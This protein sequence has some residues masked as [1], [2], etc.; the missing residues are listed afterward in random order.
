[1]SP[2]PLLIL[3]LHLELW[4]FG[5]CG[6]GTPLRAGGRLTHTRAFGCGLVT[7]TL[8]AD[9]AFLC[10]MD[11]TLFILTDFS[12]FNFHAIEEQSRNPKSEWYHGWKGILTYP[13]ENRAMLKA[14]A[15]HPEW[16]VKWS[17]GWMEGLPIR[18]PSYH[19]LS[20]RGLS[21]LRGMGRSLHNRTH[22]THQIQRRLMTLYR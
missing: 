5:E 11:F 17:E 18:G 16:I 19:G 4:H 9:F 22:Q 3:P 15:P 12:V 7:L 14:L 8:L 13:Q 1:M 21:Y 2:P 6:S 10:L 20:Y